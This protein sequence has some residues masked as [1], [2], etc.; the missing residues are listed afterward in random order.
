MLMI[1]CFNL[2]I[3]LCLQRDSSRVLWGTT[4][5]AIVYAVVMVL[6]MALLELPDYCCIPMT[7]VDYL[8]TCLFRLFSS[9]WLFLMVEM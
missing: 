6:L 4:D 8:M 7:T 9:V 1:P 2:F 3:S 5:G